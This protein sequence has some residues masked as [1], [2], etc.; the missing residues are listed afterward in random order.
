MTDAIGFLLF[1]PGLRTITGVCILQWITNSRKFT[2]FVNLSSDPFTQKTGAHSATDNGQPPFGFAQQY[3]QQDDSED[4]IE[5]EF[6]E[7]PDPKSQLDEKKG[8]R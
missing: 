4:V 1:I 3:R 8:P 5:G 7:R 6:E 2:K